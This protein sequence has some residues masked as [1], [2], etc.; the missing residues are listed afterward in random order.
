MKKDFAWNG[1]GECWKLID[2]QENVPPSWDKYLTDQEEYWGEDRISGSRSKD[3]QW[4]GSRS[5]WLEITREE[6]KS[7]V[8]YCTKWHG[9][10]SKGESIPVLRTEKNNVLKLCVIKNDK[11]TWHDTLELWLLNDIRLFPPSRKLK[12]EIYTFST[13]VDSRGNP[14][15]SWSQGEYDTRIRQDKE[16]TIGDA[17]FEI[18][19]T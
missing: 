5:K 7:Y 6:Y 18:V 19:S 14:C 4:K 10:F 12:T 3:W 16:V 13:T 9:K 11:T 1:V 17:V 2:F 8:D 15:S